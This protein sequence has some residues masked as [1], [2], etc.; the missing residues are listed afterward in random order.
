MPCDAL[1]NLEGGVEYGGSPLEGD[2]LATKSGPS[3][4]GHLDPAPGLWL[5]RSRN[6]AL[7]R[8]CAR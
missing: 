6:L 4:E 1:D 5:G 2:Q 8:Q 3:F 7:L